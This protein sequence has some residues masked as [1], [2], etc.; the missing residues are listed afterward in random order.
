MEGPSETGGCV[1]VV[2]T[3]HQNLYLMLSSILA[4]LLRGPPSQCAIRAFV[5]LFL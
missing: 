5:K 3:V 2:R 4:A 1:F